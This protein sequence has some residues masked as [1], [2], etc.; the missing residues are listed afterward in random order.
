VPGIGVPL[1]GERNACCVTRVC[2]PCC[3]ND[4]IT[5]PQDRCCKYPDGKHSDGETARCVRRLLLSWR[6]VVCL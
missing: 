6:F 3:G 2:Q 1:K 5:G 4:G